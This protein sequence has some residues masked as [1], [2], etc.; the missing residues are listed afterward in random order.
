MV[1]LPMVVVD[2]QRF[3]S[4]GAVVHH[5]VGPD[6]VLATI[7]GRVSMVLIELADGGV[8]GRHPT[9]DVQILMV[10]SGRVVV[11][12]GDGACVELSAGQAVEFAAGELHET[13]A[14]EASVL[15][16]LEKR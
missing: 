1:K 9:T 2:L 7:E 10:A 5:P 11:S 12:G 8:V 15:A 16:V 4:S 14:L 3:G 13:R 6:G